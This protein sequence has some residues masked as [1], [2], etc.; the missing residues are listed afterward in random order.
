MRV[1]LTGVSSFTGAWFARA[2]ASAGAEVLAVPRRDPALWEPERR[3]RLALVPASVRILPA[4]PFG[5]PRFLELLERIGPL[6]LLA[7]HGAE[8][9][10]HR[11]PAFDVEAAVAANTRNVEAVMETAARRGVRAVLVT[12]SLFEA[13]EGAGEEPLR[14]FNPYG[15]SKTRSFQRLAEAARRRGLAVGKFVVGHPVGPF[16]KPGLLRAFT[17]A[18]LRGGIPRL[19]HPQL[20]RD[21]QPVDR[22]ARAYAGFAF[23]LAERAGGIHRLVPRGFTGP[24]EELVEGIAA[25][26]R[27]P[28]GLP[29]RFTVADPPERSGEPLCRIGLHPLH[30]LVPDWDEEAFFA[31]WAAV[32]RGGSL[33]LA[34]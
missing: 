10:D 7:L 12:G 19:R 31:G 26:L 8:A 9:R 28:L 22:L 32:L 14:A 13:G 29:C 23:A 17:E 27:R 34:A 4:A 24:L 33:P 5:S 16:D 21:M 1:L 30:L 3:A 2:L 20:V 25:G 6:D 11:S 18:W 15:L